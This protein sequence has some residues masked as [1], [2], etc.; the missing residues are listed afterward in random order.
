MFLFGYVIFIFFRLLMGLF[1][2]FI[3]IGVLKFIGIKDEIW[4]FLSNLDEF[5]FKMCY[6]ILLILICFVIQFGVVYWQLYYFN[7]FWYFVLIVDICLVQIMIKVIFMVLFKF[8][9]QKLLSKILQWDLMY[10][11]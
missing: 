9:V 6:I 10:C 5:V 7:N 2:I 4:I 11:C 3:F 1:I 8:Y